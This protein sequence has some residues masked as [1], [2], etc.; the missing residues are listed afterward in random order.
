LRRASAK[1][2]QSHGCGSGL[3]AKVGSFFF[4]VGM[5]IRILNIAAVQNIPAS[6]EVLDRKD[7]EG[8]KGEH[9]KKNGWRHF[10]ASSPISHA[11]PDP[12]P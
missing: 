10:F 11:L 7:S 3:G 1:H 8:Q 2:K 4:S 6:N 5:V 9:Q 12:N